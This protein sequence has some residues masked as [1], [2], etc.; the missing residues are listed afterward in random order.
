MSRSAESREHLASF[1]QLI[2]MSVGGRRGARS[3]RL[4]YLALNFRPA[5]LRR[6]ASRVAICTLR[7]HD[8]LL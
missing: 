3:R 5:H 1:A 6:L 7:E 8:L 4:G 2:T